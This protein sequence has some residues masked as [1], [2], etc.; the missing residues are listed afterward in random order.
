MWPSPGHL[1]GTILEAEQRLESSPL[2][3][4]H[5]N[6]LIAEYATFYAIL[7]RT[8]K[9]GDRFVGYI[10][11]RSIHR[12]HRR[13]HSCLTRRTAG[14]WA[15]HA[16]WR[17]AKRARKRDQL[18]EL[19][20]RSERGGMARFDRPGGRFKVAG[21]AHGWT[22]PAWVWE[23]ARARAAARRGNTSVNPIEF[24]EVLVSSPP[25]RER[26][27]TPLSQTSDG[28]YAHGP[29]CVCEQ[30]FGRDWRSPPARKYS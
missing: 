18:V 3:R 15:D 30:C 14:G 22:F 11:A 29:R 8:G 25:S 17:A 28:V 6:L 2:Q 23:A 5:H 10:G 27:P 16:C 1:R 24:R 13:E 7:Q 26:R 12:E 9:L 20:F 21:V 19:T 4:A